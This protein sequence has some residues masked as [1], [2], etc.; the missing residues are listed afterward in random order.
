MPVAT[1]IFDAKRDRELIAAGTHFWCEGCLTAQPKDDQSPDPRYCQRCCDFLSR[2]AELLTGW[3]RPSWVPK[4]AKE[5]SGEKPAADKSQEATKP[6]K[7]PQLRGTQFQG[8]PPQP[9][10]DHQSIMSTPASEKSEGDIIAPSVSVVTAAK[11]GPKHKILPEDRIRRW[12]KKMGSKA[13]ATKLREELG[14]NVS[15]KTIQRILNG[16]R[17]LS[18]PI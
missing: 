15:Y 17:Q 13:I 8:I 6:S 3:Q 16:K 5:R 14:I 4:L 2:E 10:A 1:K 18:F 11:R 12:G 9:P 7:P